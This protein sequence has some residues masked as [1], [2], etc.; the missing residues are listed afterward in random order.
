MLRED[1][2]LLAYGEVWNVAAL[3]C[4]RA[5]GFAPVTAIEQRE[6]NRGQ[7]IEYVWLR[8]AFGAP[9]PG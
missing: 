8:R 2:D 3:A 7:P 6:F 5:A 1:G 9:E 4:Y